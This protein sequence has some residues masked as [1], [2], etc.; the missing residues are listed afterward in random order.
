VRILGFGTYDV[1]RHPRVGV[2]LEGLR[3]H[4]DTVLE[5]NAPLGFSTAERVAM[6]GK[7]WTAYRL[8]LRLSR[9]WATL[10]TSSIR[11]RRQGHR[12]AV[13]V[14]YLGHFDVLLARLL[15]PRD[16][17]VLDQM[18]F[19]ADTAMDRGVKSSAKL[20][21][22]RLI[23]WLAV[24]AADVVLLDAQEQLALVPK[25]QRGKAVV[26]A[27]G[28]PQ[29]WFDAAHSEDDRR[30]ND[31]DPVRVLFVGVFT[32]LHGA[33]AI[34]EALGQLTGHDELAFT[35]VGTGQDWDQAR[36]LAADNHN[37]AWHEWVDAAE[38]PGLVA[39]HDV[40][41]GI[42]GTTPKAQRVVPNKVYQ[43]AAANCAI[44]T[45]DTPPQ[46]RALGDAAVFVP[47]GDP[48]A[49]ANALV[50]LAK[51]RDSIDTLGRSAHQRA[52]TDF[53]PAAIVTV[54]R[55]RLIGTSE[56]AQTDRGEAL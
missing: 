32:P 6:L 46:R 55:D 51:D 54:L 49:L 3:V 1:A 47:P 2:I 40:C 11:A 22:L 50:T 19:A 28:S 7:P 4:G 35:M 37:V 23:D 45:S 12:D 26:V 27:V 15:F 34:G 16:R 48:S 41:L 44:V 10:L 29:A 14:G 39:D 36:R 24:T 56:A 20:R 5:V 33:T 18:I 21:L 52:C 42:F 31:G 13:L 25:R 9:R 30:S 43:G 8:L 53:T 17:I 38:L